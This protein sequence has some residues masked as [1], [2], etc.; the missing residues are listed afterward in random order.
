MGAKYRVLAKIKHYLKRQNKA[1]RNMRNYIMKYCD[2]C[3]YWCIKGIKNNEKRVFY[4]IYVEFIVTTNMWW[5]F[6]ACFEHYVTY[7]S[8]SIDSKF[9]WIL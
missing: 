4:H 6:T 9:R 7:E 3:K 8:I 5:K 2:V 1:N